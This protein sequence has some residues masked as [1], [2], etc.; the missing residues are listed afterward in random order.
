[1]YIVL[2]ILKQRSL[3]R[4]YQ[5]PCPCLDLWQ[6]PLFQNGQQLL[7]SSYL[8]KVWR[9]CPAT[10]VFLQKCQFD[11]APSSYWSYICQAHKSSQKFSIN[12]VH[13]HKTMTK[14]DKKLKSIGIKVCKIAQSTLKKTVL[15]EHISQNMG[16]DFPKLKNLI[17]SRN[18]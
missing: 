14:K 15:R 6:W 10:E 16:L 11:G 7:C 5:S 8:P 2:P 9:T 3:L 4:L 17:L 13:V 18:T 12:I 1:M